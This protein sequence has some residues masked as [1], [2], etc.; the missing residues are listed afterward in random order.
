MMMIMMMMTAMR[1]RWDEVGYIFLRRADHTAAA[2]PFSASD[3]RARSIATNATRASLD[4][5][6]TCSEYRR[7][8]S[9]D[10]RT[11]TMDRGDGESRNQYQRRRRRRRRRRRQ[12]HRGVKRR[13]VDGARKNC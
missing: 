8:I 13:G 12:L 5:I 1:M 7:L 10:E 3:G 9:G 2:S 6:H 4:N 11:K